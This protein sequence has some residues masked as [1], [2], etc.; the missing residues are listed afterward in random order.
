MKGKEFWSERPGVC[1]WR[2]PPQG[3]DRHV[4]AVWIESDPPRD[5]LALWEPLPVLKCTVGEIDSDAVFR[6]SFPPNKCNQMQRLLRRNCD[7]ILCKDKVR[8][9]EVA[10]DFHVSFSGAFR[11][12]TVCLTGTPDVTAY[13]MYPGEQRLSAGFLCVLS[14]RGWG[15][16]HTAEGGCDGASQGVS[17]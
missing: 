2:G 1:V 7:C 8:E 16:G 5:C 10:L 13:A 12:P 15:L 6:S 17:L 11:E 3:S 14:V 4:L 9:D